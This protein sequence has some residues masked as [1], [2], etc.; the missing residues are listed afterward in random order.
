MEQPIPQPNS[1]DAEGLNALEAQIRECYGR[2]AYSH[3]THEKCADI[4]HSRLGKVKISQ[5]VLAAIT[6]GGLIATLLGQNPVSTGLAAIS[7]TVLLALNTYTKENDFGELAQ[8][9][10]QAAGELWSVRESYLSL[11]T[12]IADKSANS[13]Q[14]REKRDELQIELKNIYKTAPRTISEAYKKAQE[15]LKVNE[16]LTFSDEEIDNMLPITLHKKKPAT[17]ES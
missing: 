4:Y 7:S 16:E 17:P 3:K 1:S 10:A 8:K 12:D 9:H 5:V 11:L 14:I 13:E 15:A 2:V 6:T